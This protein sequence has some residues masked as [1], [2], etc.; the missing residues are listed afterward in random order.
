MPY[1]LQMRHALIQELPDRA[2]RLRVHAEALEAETDAR[3]QPVF[4]H[5]YHPLL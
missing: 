5:H 1:M 4:R 3:T 2:E